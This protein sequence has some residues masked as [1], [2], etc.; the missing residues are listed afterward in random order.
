METTPTTHSNYKAFE[1]E[2]TGNNGL[3]NNV[4]WL[5]SDRTVFGVF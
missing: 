4:P 3:A 2:E 5:K 1:E